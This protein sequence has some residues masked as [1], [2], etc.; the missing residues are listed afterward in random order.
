MPVFPAP[1]LGLRRRHRRLRPQLRPRLRLRRRGR[2]RRLWRHLLTL[3]RY[4]RWSHFGPRLR[5]RGRLCH[6]TA[7]L[8][9]RSLLSLHRR[10]GTVGRFLSLRSLRFRSRL[11]L[12]LRRRVEWRLLLPGLLRFRTRLRWRRRGRRLMRLGPVRSP[13][14][15]RHG[16]ER[17]RLTGRRSPLRVLRRLRLRAEFRSARFGARLRRN[18]TR[19][20]HGGMSQNLVRT[21]GGRMILG[22]QRLRRDD[23]RR[24]ENVQRRK[25]AIFCLAF[26]DVSEGG[27]GGAEI[28]TDLHRTI[29]ATNEY[30]CTRM[31]SQKF[32]FIRVYS[33]LMMRLPFLLR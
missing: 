30:E 16:L 33:R 20:N 31:E 1:R 9:S 11:S 7:L 29:S 15:R 32:V 21:R 10:H 12:R 3:Q 25:I 27:V 28:N 24:L 6:R 19:R 4:R 5:H 14:R 17:L 13:L 23:L 26:V 22:P 2:T 8:R 18:G